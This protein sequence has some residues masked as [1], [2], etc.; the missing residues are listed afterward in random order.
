MAFQVESNAHPSLIT[1]VLVFKINKVRK[2]EERIM[3]PDQGMGG[4]LLLT[5]ETRKGDRG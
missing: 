4:H 2:R 3:I 5:E 1:I